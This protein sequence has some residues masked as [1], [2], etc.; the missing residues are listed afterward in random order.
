MNLQCR[1]AFKW[2]RIGESGELFEHG[3][4]FSAP[5]KFDKLLGQLSSY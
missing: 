5:I 1:V 3:I 2:L 4:T